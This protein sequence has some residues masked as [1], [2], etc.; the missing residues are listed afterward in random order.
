M[1]IDIEPDRAALTL[2]PYELSLVSYALEQ[3]EQDFT[4]LESVGSATPGSAK[5]F[6]VIIDSIGDA[7]QTLSE[8]EHEAFLQESKVQL[9]SA[10][11]S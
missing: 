4:V 6:G 9:D 2:A 1:K 5:V 7:L 8:E 10:I 11:G 3:A